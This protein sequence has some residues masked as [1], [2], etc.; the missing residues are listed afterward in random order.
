MAMKPHIR[1]LVV[2]VAAGVSAVPVSA[3]RTAARPHRR[4]R[5]RH[6]REGVARG[7][8]PDA[9]LLAARARRCWRGDATSP[10][11]SG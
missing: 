9:P 5:G 1:A 8:R 6:H 4:P 11:A 2:F 10:A 3:Q 7:R